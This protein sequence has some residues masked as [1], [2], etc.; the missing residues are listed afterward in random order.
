MDDAFMFMTKTSNWL[1]E[2]LEFFHH[3][4]KFMVAS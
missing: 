4:N 2:P 1:Q 3:S